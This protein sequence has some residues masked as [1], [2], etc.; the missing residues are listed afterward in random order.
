MVGGP[1][2]PELASSNGDRR[3]ARSS[4]RIAGMPCHRRNEKKYQPISSANVSYL[5]RASK[6]SKHHP[7]LRLCFRY[8]N[9][10]PGSLPLIELVSSD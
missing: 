10:Y 5:S 1:F 4:S 9:R 7:K 3:H 2:F 6:D 8:R